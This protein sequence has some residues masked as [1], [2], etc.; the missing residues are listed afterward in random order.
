MTN[1]AQRLRRWSRAA[2]SRRC[3]AWCA[4][5]S[6]ICANGSGREYQISVSKQ[7]LSREIAGHRI[8]Q[9][10]GAPTPSRAE[11]GRRRGF[12]KKWPATLA[13]IA[14]QRGV[15]AGDIEVWFGD[16]AR[17]GQKNKITRRW[18]KRGVPAVGGIGPAH[19]VNLHL[20]RHLSQRRQGC[21]LDPALVQHGD[22][23]PASGGDLG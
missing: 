13:A 1:N 16:E 21:R 7:T 20:R 8:P 4:G 3:T 19:R 10:V 14:R 18:A 5:A 17:I 6:S 15:D 22:D 2:R 9:A 23:E 11:G 12:Q